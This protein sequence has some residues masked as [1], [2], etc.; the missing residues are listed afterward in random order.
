MS[1]NKTYSCEITGLEFDIWN[2]P[3]NPCDRKHLRNKEFNLHYYFESVADDKKIEKSQ[4]SIINIEIDP[5]DF[6]LMLYTKEK[7]YTLKSHNEVRKELALRM[8]YINRTFNIVFDHLN[9]QLIDNDIKNTMEFLISQT[10]QTQKN[11]EIAILNNKIEQQNNILNM[12]A[13]HIKRLEDKI[14]R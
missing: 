12:F 14:N 4:W 11:D 3:R 5:N 9:Q 8:Y 1:L 13:L 2:D 10:E 6:N 7:Q